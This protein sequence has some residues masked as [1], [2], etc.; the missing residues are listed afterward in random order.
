M[1]NDDPTI[2]ALQE[3]AY[4]LFDKEQEWFTHHYNMV[5][6]ARALV[7]SGHLPDMDALLYYIEKPYKWTAEWEHYAEYGYTHNYDEGE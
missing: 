6:L 3:G 7:N 5:A 1:D 4:L 2:K